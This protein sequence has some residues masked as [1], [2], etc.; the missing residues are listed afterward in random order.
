MSGRR[1]QA[2]A[3]IAGIVLVAIGL[4]LPGAP[5]KTADHVEDVTRT[6]VDHRGE[7]L[8][9]AYAIGIGC[10]LLLLFM[11]ALRARIGDGPFGSAAFGAGVAGVALLMTGV[12]TIDGLAFTA[13]GMGDGAVVRALVDA[14]NAQIAMAGLALA[15][16][17][18][19]ASATDALPRPLRLLGY[20]G[21]AWLAI[22]G[23]SLSVDSGP[24]QA[25]GVL[26]LSGTLPLVVWIAA[27]SVVMLRSSG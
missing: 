17:L 9:S 27:A 3:G 4:V 18:V 24:F 6:L 23:V 7:F 5:P 10:V 22:T 15:G 8:V 14:G 25:G 20:A 12:A 19:A 16:L 1:A 13:A 26:N 2:A 11:G 21:A